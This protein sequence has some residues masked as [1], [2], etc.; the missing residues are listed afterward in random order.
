MTSNSDQLKIPIIDFSNIDGSFENKQTIGHA[1]GQ[2]CENVGFFIIT[3]HGVDQDIIS[4]IWSSTKEFFDL[5]IHQKTKLELDQNTYAYGYTSIGGE[6]LSSGKSFETKSEIVNSPD[7]KEMFSIGPNN[8][9]YPTRLFPDQPET[10]GPAWTAYYEAISTLAKK[11]LSVVA[12]E[13]N[14][15]ITYFDEFMTKHGSALRALNYPQ[16]NNSQV[17]VGQ[18]RASAHT[19]Y[20]IFTILKS[21]G[22]G[23][24]VSKDVNPPVWSNVPVIDNGFIVNIGDL[25]KRWTNDKVNL[26]VEIIIVVECFYSIFRHCIE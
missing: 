8:S 23:L 1:I 12:I 17:E 15:P 22:P 6:I 10:F 19:D 16:I 7:L 24:Q 18:L 20:G 5:D 11:L 14:L 4:N 13:L 9:E 2:A 25:M 26:D 3:N 21:D